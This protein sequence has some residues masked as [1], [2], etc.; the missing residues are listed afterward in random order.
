MCLLLCSIL[1]DVTCVFQWAFWNQMNEIEIFSKIV[2]IVL[3]RSVCWREGCQGLAAL[4]WRHW[5]K[6]KHLQNIPHRR[7]QG[8]GMCQR[9]GRCLRHRFENKPF[10]LGQA[11]YCNVL[12]LHVWCVTCVIFYSGIDSVEKLMTRQANKEENHWPKIHWESSW[13]LSLCSD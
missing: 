4:H 7:T 9:L 12:L 8:E 2:I 1:L 13:I 6:D 10:W 3:N 11:K 5:D